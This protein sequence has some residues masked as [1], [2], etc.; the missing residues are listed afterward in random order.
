[1]PTGNTTLEAV[2]T[3]WGAA[4]REAAR[5]TQPKRSYVN[6]AQGNETVQE[7][8]GY[9]QWRI[10]KLKGLKQKYDPRGQFNFFAPIA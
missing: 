4:M 1:M 9:E 5:G 3:T 10:N 6:Y 8:Y 2:A 7:I